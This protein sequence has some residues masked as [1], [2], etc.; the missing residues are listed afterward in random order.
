LFRPLSLLGRRGTRELAKAELE[1]REPTGRGAVMGFEEERGMK[2][3]TILL[4]KGEES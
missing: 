4:H 3:N 1:G 2:K